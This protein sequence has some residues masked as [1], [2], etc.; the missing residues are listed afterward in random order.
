MKLI[1]IAVGLVLVI[2]P[3]GT[4]DPQAASLGGRVID[5]NKVGIAL[6]TVSTRNVFSGETE[7]ARTSL[8]G[9]YRFAGLRQGRY[10]VFAQ[11]EGYG[12]R[13]IMNVILRRGEHTQLD[14]VLTASRKGGPTGGCKE[15]S[16]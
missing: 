12:C 14:L 11:A 2:A 16:E 4:D 9:E 6:A 8:T 5:E 3:R 1:S 7:Y 15:S 13:W 10:S